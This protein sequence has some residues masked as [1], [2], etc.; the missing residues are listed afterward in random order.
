MRLKHMVKDKINYRA[1]GPN[2][3]LTRQPVQ[4]RANDGG[5]RIG[6]MERDGVMAHG[7]SFFLN[8][9][10]MVRGDEYFMAVCNKTGATAIYNEAKSLFLSPFADG[11]INFNINHDGTMNI[12]NLSKFG[13]SFSIVRIPYSLKLLLQELQVRNVQMRIITDENVD[14]LMNLSY[15]MNVHKLMNDDGTD[16]SEL[17]NKLKNKFAKDKAP[18]KMRIAS[19]SQSS[20]SWD[21]DNEDE[22]EFS[23]E[24]PDDGEE[25]PAYPMVVYPFTETKATIAI[26]TLFR[27]NDKGAREK[28]RKEFIRR[29]NR[30]MA[31]YRYH[32][33]IIEQ[34]ADGH[35]FNIGKLKNVGFKIAGEWEKTHDMKFTNFIFSDIDMIPDDELL[36][37]Y[38]KPIKKPLSLAIRGTRY[39]ARDMESKKIFLGA[40]LGFN[41]H[42][43]E[44]INGYPDNFWGWGGE[45]DALLYRLVASDV[46][47]VQ[48]PKVGAVI[49][50]EEKKT[51]AEKLE[52]VVK[53]N[54]R[55]EKLYIDL[56]MWQKN[57]LSNLNYKLMKMTDAAENTTQY[58]VDLQKLE[59]EK[60][61]P[62]LFKTEGL[63]FDWKKD[64]RLITDK[65]DKLRVEILDFAQQPQTPDSFEMKPFEPVRFDSSYSPPYAPSLPNQDQLIFT[66]KEKVYYYEDR[67]RPPIIC[68]I[69]ELNADGTVEIVDLS[70]GRIIRTTIGNL[71]KIPVETNSPSP[72]QAPSQRFSPHSPSPVY[73]PKS[74]SP[75]FSPHS[76]EMP[77]KTTIFDVEEEKTDEEKEE[78]KDTDKNNGEKKIIINIKPE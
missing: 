64:K 7:M 57:G 42:D 27:D 18:N 15:S 58:L 23:P 11:P 39:D 31:P 52:S 69:D 9:S 26:I 71:A 16:T 8:E 56:T 24:T 60:N 59:D 61:Y 25:S 62:E 49:D 13:R 17:I 78:E 65:Y 41:R 53:D 70:D 50:L 35:P 22:D 6:E 12:K 45:D 3:M 74:P 46:G 2:T 43:F 20:E 73:E 21:G 28:Q 33:F 44:E 55:W 1:R 14:Q 5:L 67:A 38:V 10:F 36:Q 51:L 76:P 37:Y 4:G 75:Q 54:Q 66:Q 72:E 77:E 32:I 30:I 34:S 63:K 47:A 19:N 48:I 68:E 29:M 40:V